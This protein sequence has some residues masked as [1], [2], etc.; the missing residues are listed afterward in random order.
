MAGIAGKDFAPL[1]TRFRP[2][3]CRQG[4]AGIQVVYE[5]GGSVTADTGQI[6]LEILGSPGNAFHIAVARL[7]PGFSLG[8]PYPFQ[9]IMGF[10]AA[11]TGFF[12]VP[13]N[14][15]GR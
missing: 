4:I 6:R 8:S 10:M 13:G 7:C 3:D 15:H 12:K 2:D 1:V 9:R 5:S 14:I 11:V